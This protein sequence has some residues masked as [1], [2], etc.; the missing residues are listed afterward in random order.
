M[1]MRG[2]TA[3]VT[4]STKGIGVAIA[5]LFAAEGANVLVTG[6]STAVGE[7]V[8]ARIRADGGSARF[9]A[10]DISDA[11]SVRRVVSECVEI[12]GGLHVLVNNAAP[13]D[14]MGKE[15]RALTDI[16]LEGFDSMLKTGL[17]GAVAATQAALPHILAAGGGA[18]V[19]ISSIAGVQG[20]SGVP[21]YSCVKGALQSFTRQ[22]A[23][24]YGKQ[25]VRSNC[26]VVGPIAHAGVTAAFLEIPIVKQ[27]FE[28]VM[29]TK[30]SRMGDARDVAEAAVFLASD[31]ARFIN[32]AQLPVD[33]GMTCLA[34]L[35]N[36]G[37]LMSRGE[38]EMG[39]DELVVS[40]MTREQA[41][42]KLAGS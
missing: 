25:G 35:P 40:G 11:A 16:S 1:R 13:V 24:D 12:F 2:K 8:A 14:Q 36:V 18:I 22:I 17:Y 6:R 26:I 42:A 28:K 19:N 23:V 27:A 32:G 21:A 41:E 33:G 10:G 37:E 31:G 39:I 3:I 5:S 34:T 29:L 30:D 4:G 15:E 38:Y 7:E 20:V 9:L